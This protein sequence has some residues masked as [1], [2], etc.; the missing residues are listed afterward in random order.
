MLFPVLVLHLPNS[1]PWH[2]A[3]YPHTFRV[4]SLP[5][6][7]LPSWL[8]IDQFEACR[9]T[10]APCRG[11]VGSQWCS[12]APS[13]GR[14]SSSLYTA[15]GLCGSNGRRKSRLLVPPCL[16]TMENAAISCTI[17]R[18]QQA[19]AQ[20]LRLIAACETSVYCGKRLG[21]YSQCPFALYHQ[22]VFIV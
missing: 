13:S 11:Q 18:V 20:T 9:D 7:S 6:L 10:A 16:M 19:W 3:F 5:H 8:A 17:I 12:W 2:T 21:P 22:T 15:K 14:M 4:S 1:I